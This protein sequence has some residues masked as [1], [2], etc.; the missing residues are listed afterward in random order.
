MQQNINKS[1]AFKDPLGVFKTVS[2]DSLI[3]Q[4]L[5]Q[6]VPL[7]CP[8]ATFLFGEFAWFVLHTE[9]EWAWKSPFQCL[10][11]IECW[12]DIAVLISQGKSVEG[13][14]I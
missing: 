11:G 14:R 6:V 12:K 1:N 8:Q 7:Q 3:L 13:S 2:F 5:I 9:K 4:I 10:F